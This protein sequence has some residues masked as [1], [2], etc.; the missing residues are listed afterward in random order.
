MEDTT[1]KEKGTKIYDCS[2]GCDV[3]RTPMGELKVSYNPR[4]CK[5]SSYD[6]TESTAFNHTVRLEPVVVEAEFK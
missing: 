1:L 2:R 5:L 4:C 6:W 3:E